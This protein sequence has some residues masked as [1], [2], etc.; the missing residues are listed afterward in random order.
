LKGQRVSIV[1]H[2]IGKQ[3]DLIPKDTLD[4]LSHYFSVKSDEIQGNLMY[5]KFSSFLEMFGTP[6]IEMFD[7]DIM[8]IPKGS[9]VDARTLD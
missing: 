9:V 5:Q 1:V 8:D 6:F 7:Q 2:N 4:I 3:T